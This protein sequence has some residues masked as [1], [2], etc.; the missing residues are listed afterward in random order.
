MD[1]DIETRV[2]GY[3][4][5]HSIDLG[6]GVVTPGVK[7]SSVCNGEASRIFDRIDLRGRS[8]LDVGAWNGFFSFEAS[9]RGA[10]RVLATDSFVWTNPHFRGR[11]AFEL[12][13]TMLNSDVESLEI[14]VSDLSPE[15]VG[16]FDVVL[17]LGVFY[18]RYDAIE[19]LGRVARLARQ[20]LVVE[21]LL[22][23]RTIDRPA[24][25]FYPGSE[26]GGDASNWWGPNEHCLDA[27]LRGH[28]FSEIEQSAHPTTDL[29]GVFHA[30]RSTD[31]RLRPP[32]EAER[33]KPITAVTTNRRRKRW[34]PFRRLFD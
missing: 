30:W 12:A 7:S 23:L 31:V 8:V 16:E 26:V 3:T 24:M 1:D 21:S 22:D 11:E 9:R 19:A 2:G 32:N 10:A 4:W 33:L 6:D 18:H 20:V 29:R 13:R 25:A 17:Y 15:T 27:L 34:R 28:G 14:D 5:F